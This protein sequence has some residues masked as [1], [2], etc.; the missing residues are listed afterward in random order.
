[1]E[2][3]WRIEMHWLSLLTILVLVTSGALPSLASEKV[4]D[5]EIYDNVRLK[6]AGDRDVRGTA[7]EVEVKNG[8]VTLRGE[9]DKEKNKQRAERLT[10][11]VKGV[12][13]VI[14][15]LT[16]APR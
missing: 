13:K 11:K 7:L 15:E 10:K 8:V 2:G 12:V 16:V 14:N 3:R 9:V 6:L 5:D 1:L 4:S